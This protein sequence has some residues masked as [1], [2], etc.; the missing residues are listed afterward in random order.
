MKVLTRKLWYTNA[1]GSHDNTSVHG[2]PFPPRVSSPLQHKQPSASQHQIRDEQMRG[3][4]DSRRG[5]GTGEKEENSRSGNWGEGRK[6]TH[7]SKVDLRA[8]EPRDASGAVVGTRQRERAEHKEEEQCGARQQQCRHDR[9]RRPPAALP[10]AAQQR[11]PAPHRRTARHSRRRVTTARSALSLCLHSRLQV[12]L[13]VCPLLCLTDLSRPGVFYRNKEEERRRSPPLALLGLGLWVAL[14]RR[15]ATRRGCWAVFL[16]I[17][18]H[19]RCLCIKGG[20]ETEFRYK[21]ISLS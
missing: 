15:G 19:G 4:R 10:A 11:P 7:E 14:Q 8:R 20:I 13:A 18:E 21:R 16:I 17:D 3:K 6:K 12:V 2:S 1:R 9:R 5:V